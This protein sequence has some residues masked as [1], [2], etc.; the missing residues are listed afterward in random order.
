MLRGRL[1]RSMR[2][3]YRALAAGSPGAHTLEPDGVLASIVPVA[4]ARSYPNAVI[5]DSAEQLEA[6]YETLARA[7]ADAGIEA[8]SV[9]VPEQDAHVARLLAERG[10]LLDALPT[11]MARELV[12]VSRPEPG[13]LETWTATGDPLAVGS[14][15]DRAYSFGDDTFAVA[16][17]GL[18]APGMRFYVGSASGEPVACLIATDDDGNCEIDGV[19]TPPEARGSGLAGQLLAHALVDAAERGCETTTLIATAL[20]RPVYERLGYR[21]LG[22]LQMWERRVT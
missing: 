7:Y 21:P 9:W 10:H 12:G 13:S 14:L 17:G 2:H 3:F 15:N 4:A 18:S 5:Y 8:W 1:D 19:A 22:T 11:A 20:G 6:S 16:F